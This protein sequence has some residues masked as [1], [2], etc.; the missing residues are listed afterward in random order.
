MTAI[1]IFIL[2]VLFTFGAAIFI[3]KNLIGKDLSEE[4]EKAL[5]DDILDN[6]NHF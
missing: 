6:L 4:E 3:A 2:Y 5:L 1:G